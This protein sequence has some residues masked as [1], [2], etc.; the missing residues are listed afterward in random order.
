MT[1]TTP[2]TTPFERRCAEVRQRPALSEA[3]ELKLAERWVKH[4]DR[5]AADQLIE[6]HLPLVVRLAKR[7][8]GYGVAHDELVAEGNVGLLRAV[9]KFELRGVRF[10]TYAS[11]WVRAHM[12]ASAQRAN[13]LVT[14][15]TGAQGA[16]F[17]FKLRSAR[18]KAEALFGP[19]SDRVEASLAEQFGV[20]E[21]VIRAHLARLG[22]CDVSL[23]ETLND[24]NDDTRLDALACTQPVADERLGRKEREQQ[25]KSTV[26]G[27]W[28]A[29]DSRE[30]AVVTER[31]M[32]DDD[33][34]TLAELGARFGLSRERLRQIEV[35][36]KDRFR[37]AL[38]E[39]GVEAHVH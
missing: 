21:D 7:L 11:Y 18:A 20:G 10:K 26:E 5:A 32:A 27:L 6:A 28:A 25:V 31:F 34:M 17:F 13:S 24:E 1:N 9:E 4:R 36:V 2:T 23:D 3:E 29:L 37:R 15:A 8:R 22:T 39:K 19:N 38:G 30:R 14:V 16:K 12:L 33:E 35:R